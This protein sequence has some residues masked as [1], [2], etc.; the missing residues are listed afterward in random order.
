MIFTGVNSDAG[1]AEI[2][3]LF[4][5]FVAKAS[6]ERIAVPS[7]GQR[8]YLSTVRLAAAVIGNSSS[9]LIEAP[10]LGTPTV[11]IGDR[12]KGRLRSPSVIDCG[13]D[14]ES[15]AAAIAKALDPVFR[16]KAARST[17]AYGRGGAAARIV[18]AL[19]TVPLAQ[20]S[21]KRFHDILPR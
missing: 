14:T 15:I 17:P 10:A 16:A 4:A 6:N 21:I 12:Q 8:G 3:K 5:A 20:L 2:A 9:G 19:K 18:A 13:E 1:H 11:N 7:L